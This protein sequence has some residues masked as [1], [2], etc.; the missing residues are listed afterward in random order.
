MAGKGRE[1]GGKPAGIPP[2]T[3]KQDRFLADCIRELLE[4]VPLDRMESFLQHGDTSCLRHCVS[5]AWLSYRMS[6]RF[7]RPCDARSLIRGAMLHD[8]FLYDWHERHG[9]HRWHGFTH[10]GTALENARLL[11]ALNP[12]E[13]NIILRHM[14]P[15]TPIPP[16]CREAWLVCLADKICSLRETAR[17]RPYALKPLYAASGIPARLARRET[18]PV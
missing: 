3:E 6:R 4:E 16:R 18:R 8:F 12:V 13:R 14:W 10:P 7:R 2:L 9:G 11:L 5:V 15:L 1:T 17:L